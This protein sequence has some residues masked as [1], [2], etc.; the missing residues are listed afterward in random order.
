MVS[1]GIENFLNKCIYIY[2]LCVCVKVDRLK[3]PISVYY[4]FIVAVVCCSL[5]PYQFSYRNF[6]IIKYAFYV[7]LNRAI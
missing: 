5:V 1:L 6:S 7:C 2:I 3:R 4:C